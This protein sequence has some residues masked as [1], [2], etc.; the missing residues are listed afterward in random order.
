[1]GL[2][3]GDDGESTNSIESIWAEL[4]R[5][6]KDAFRKMSP[7][8]T[9]RYLDELA[10]RLNTRDLDTLDHMAVIA[11]GLVGKSLPRALL[12]S[13]NGL[14]NYAMKPAWHNQQLSALDDF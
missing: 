4:K 2:Y 1:M 8:H 6:V 3:V 14:A 5:A 7:K 13:D 9:R 10:G 11:K 12:I